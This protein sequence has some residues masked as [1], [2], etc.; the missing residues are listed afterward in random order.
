MQNLGSRNMD[1]AWI[2]STTLSCSK[3]APILYTWIAHCISLK[4]PLLVTME[5]CLS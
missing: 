5:V 3:G 2:K 1:H 4:S